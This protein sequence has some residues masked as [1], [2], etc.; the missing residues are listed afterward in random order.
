[1]ICFALTIFALIMVIRMHDEMGAFLG[2]MGDVG[3]GH[4]TEEKMFGLMAFG[5]VGVIIVGVVKILAGRD[6]H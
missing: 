2:C 4:T 6:R 5:L 1:M 3:P